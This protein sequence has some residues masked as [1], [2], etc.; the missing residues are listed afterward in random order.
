V[1]NNGCTRLQ[2]FIEDT[3]VRIRKESETNFD[4]IART[5]K[6][7]RRKDKIAGKH[8]PETI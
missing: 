2:D 3:I 4:A 5:A 1:L 8:Q 6:E 7:S